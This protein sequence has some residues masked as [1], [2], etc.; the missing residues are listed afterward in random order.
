LKKKEK[1][2]KLKIDERIEKRIPLTMEQ[3]DQIFDENKKLFFGVQHVS[4]DFY[5]FEDIY[6]KYYEGK[7]LL[8][9]DK[10]A[11]YHREYKW[12]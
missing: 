12:S 5:I 4:I 1:V 7:D 2:L 3:Y 6:K 9:L 8:A 10:I 11:A